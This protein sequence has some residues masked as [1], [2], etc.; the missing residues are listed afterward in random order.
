MMDNN[1]NIGILNLKQQIWDTSVNI[2]LP[3]LMYYGINIY[4]YLVDNRSIRE[5]RRM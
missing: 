3:P 5:K 1:K 4:I 2:A